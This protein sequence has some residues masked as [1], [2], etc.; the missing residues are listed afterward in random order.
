MVLK[1]I[2]KVHKILRK[3]VDFQGVDIKKWKSSRRVT[4]N[5]TRNPEGKLQKKNRYRRQSTFFIW[6]KP[7]TPSCLNNCIKVYQLLK[8]YIL[9]SEEYNHGL[10]IN[11]LDFNQYAG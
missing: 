6:K 7:I 4:V 2:A 11:L 9:K 5:S 3:N 8:H 1:G 10:K